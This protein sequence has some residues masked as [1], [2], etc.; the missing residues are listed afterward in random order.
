MN[1]LAVAVPDPRRY[2]AG[3]AP[4]PFN[5]LAQPELSHAVESALAERRDDELAAAFAAARSR[6]EYCRLWQTV[7]ELVHEP[8]DDP[9]AARV[10]VFALPLVIISGSASPAQLPGMLHD[11]AAIRAIFEEHGALGKARN[12]GLS[13]ALCALTTLEAFVPG[14]VYAWTHSAGATPREFNPAPIAIEGRGEQVELRFLVGAAIVGGCEP[15]ITETASN[16]GV[17]GMPLTRAVSA[18]LAASGVETLALPRPPR[19]L[20]RAPHAGRSAQLETAFDL[21]TSNAL[22]RFRTTVGDPVAIVAGYDSGELRVSLTS[23]FDDSMLEGYRWPLHP[24]DDIAQVMTTIGELLAACRID[25]LY[26]VQATQPAQ[27]VP[28]FASVRDLDAARAIALR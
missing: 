21:Y 14:E 4:H 6:E 5:G 28:A 9:A 7:C 15:S 20:L 18:Q 22:R 19:D 8:A 17:W 12:F 27:A 10:G 23:Q 16:I 11:V 13:N 2:G 25:T 26:C 24:L 3:R 1:T